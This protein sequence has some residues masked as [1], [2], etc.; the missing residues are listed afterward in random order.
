[1]C[2]DSIYL[3]NKNIIKHNLMQ[4]GFLNIESCGICLLHAVGHLRLCGIILNVLKDKGVAGNNSFLHDT[5][6]QYNMASFD[7]LFN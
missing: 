6:F 2:I 7:L 3:N 1:M 4:M 5:Y